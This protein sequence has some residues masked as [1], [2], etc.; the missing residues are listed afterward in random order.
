MVRDAGWSGSL[1]GRRSGALAGAS[2]WGFGSVVALEHGDLNPRLLDLDP[3]GPPEVSAGVLAEELLHPDRETRVARRGGE[4]RVARL[5]RSGRRAALPEG[6]GWRLAPDPDGALDALRVEETAVSEVPLEVGQVRVAVEASGVNFHD[7]MVG[8]RLVDVEQALGGEV[9]GR[10]VDVGPGVERLSP[11]DRV[12][13]FAAGTFGPEVVTRA[14]LLAPVPE[15]VSALD[16]ATVPVAFV[17]AALA[18]E[19]AEASS[20]LGRGDRV[21][22]HAGTGGVGQA[23]IQ[24][25]LSSGLSVYATASAPKQEYLRSLGVSGVFNSRDT[26]FGEGTLRRRRAVR[27]SGWC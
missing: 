7:V 22:V 17:T 8:M 12:A 25:A 14:E 20:K 21:L 13:G 16:A 15:G 4:R 9:C 6:G 18:F 11:G 19:F 1:G 24:L 27:V 23:A 26:S 10:V 5:T 2:L 3:E